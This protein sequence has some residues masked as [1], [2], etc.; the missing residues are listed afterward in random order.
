[1]PPSP[2]TTSN[3]GGYKI[4]DLFEKIKTRKL[5]YKA[6]DL[7]KEP[8]GIFTLPALTAGSQRQGLNNYVPRAGATL[9]REV[10][11]L[12]ANGNP[13]CFF[14]SRDFT[15]LQDAYA[16]QWARERWQPSSLQ[17]LFFVCAITKTISGKFDWNNKSGWEHVKGEEIL[18]PVRDAEIDFAFM[19]VFVRAVEK[20]VVRSV[21]EYADK[22]IAATREVC[23]NLSVG[24][25]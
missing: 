7:P 23:G 19:E 14:Q 20:E 6:G 15:V 18:L 2:P 16:I 3:G 17:Q 4:G 21:V 25:Q 10:I 1:M 5:P 24:T 11:S 13:V 12:S 8:T 22:Q 9:L